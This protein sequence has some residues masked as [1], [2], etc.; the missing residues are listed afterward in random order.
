MAALAINIGPV[1]T[2]ELEAWA[3]LTH[4]AFLAP[5]RPTTARLDLLRK[6]SADQRF[7]VA[8][9]G[10]VACGTYRTWDADLPVPGGSTV[11]TLAITS[12]SVLTSH[13]RRGVA[14][15]LMASSLAEAREQGAALGYLIASEGGIY[16]RFGFGPAS[17]TVHL[18]VS[19]PRLR[20]GA[21]LTEGIDL[22]ATDDLALRQVAPELYRTVSAGLPGALPR[23]DLWWDMSCGVFPEAGE[24]GLAR[25]AVIARDAAGTVVGTASYRIKGDWTLSTQAGIDLLDL[26]ASTPAA[27]R[28]LWRYLAD[29]DLTDR[30]VAADRPVHEP[31]AWMV[32]DR[33]AIGETN[34]TDFQW[35]RIVDVPAALT[36]RRAQAPGQVVVEVTDP[37]GYA[38]GRWQIDADENGE[39]GV[40][41][42][43]RTADVTLPVSTLGSVYLG[44][45]PLTRLHLAGLADEHRA[46]TVRRLDAMLTWTPTAMVG[47]TWF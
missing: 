22:E 36:A 33:R 15:A 6:A 26:T 12:V 27:Y 11:K 8:R 2:D 20:F 41:A 25:P 47:H 43:T 44:Q 14:T 18:T 39:V 45:N 24:E 10:D 4:R 31:L 16:G 23:S 3:T 1:G 30:I 40:T 21:G 5:H 29:L 7:R 34:R 9:I 38:A 35:V 37:A 28:A 17:E 46:G 42:S 32:T 19:S 13:R